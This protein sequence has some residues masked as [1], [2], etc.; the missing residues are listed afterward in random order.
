V[1]DVVL[2][3]EDLSVE[4]HTD[5]GVIRAVDGVSFE[6]RSG[7]ILG[8]VGESG[9]GKSVSCLS[10]MGLLQKPAA[11]IVKGSIQ[12][13]GKELTRLGEEELRQIRGRDLSM[14]F[15]DPFTSL[16]PYL[17]IST[18]LME[19]MEFH[20][21]LSSGR[22][23]KRCLEVLDL[24]GVPDAEM[25]MQS[26][27]HQ[28]SGGLKQRIMIA[29]SLLL[30]PKLIIADEPTTALDVTIQAQILELIKKIN[31]LQKTSVIMITHDLGVVAGLCHRVQVMYAGRVVESGLTEEVFYQTRHP[32]TAGL[33]QSIPNLEMKVGGRLKPIPGM[34]P[35]LS[36][37]G[38]FCAFSDRCSKANEQ[39][40]SQRPV[41]EHESGEHR[42]ACFRPEGARSVA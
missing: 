39:C 12:F 20:S 21:T 35:D 5:A 30:E 31:E 27:P 17:K 28:L 7:E 11:R 33:L 36:R 13:M 41:L 26:Y 19:V 3:V 34:P 25:R 4:F 1:S 38:S 10:I 22:A 8:I 24:L 14:I 40:R 15:Q 23:Y 9:S 16:N 29:M 6:V 2:K 37:V 32:Y 18:Q 42:F